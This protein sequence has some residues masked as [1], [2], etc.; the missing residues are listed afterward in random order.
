MK[1]VQT[2]DNSITF[3]SDEYDETY[4]STSGAIEESFKKFA[5]PSKIN[6]ISKNKIYI[7]DICFGLGYN[8]LAGIVE[9]LKNKNISEIIIY[10]LEIDKEIIQKALDI[11]IMEHKEEYEIIKDAIR[12]NDNSYE[13]M[14]NEKKITINLIIA[15]ARKSVKNL[16]ETNI[17]FDYIFQDPFSPKKCPILWTKQFFTNVYKISNENAIL[18]TY[19]CARIVKDNLKEA[20][21][22]VYKGPCVGRRAPSTIAIK[23]I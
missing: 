7:L 4:H 9:G 16:Y 3:Y 15:D 18:T 8:S 22:N 5:I 10:G 17:K 20:G 2:K 21:F 14:Y 12:S 19:S 11:E 13:I 1:E 6:L 23:E